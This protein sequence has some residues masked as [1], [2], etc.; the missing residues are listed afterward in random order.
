MSPFEIRREPFHEF[1]LL[2]IR[3]QD[4]TA[5]DDKGGSGIKKDK[6]E[7]VFAGNKWF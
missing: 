5:R 2:V 4:K 3:L 6:P 7:R 1:C